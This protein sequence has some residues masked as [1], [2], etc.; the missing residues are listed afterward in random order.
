MLGY[1]KG[2]VEDMKNVKD[3]EDQLKKWQK[4]LETAKA[5]YNTTI[6]DE[7]E[8]LYLGTRTIDPNINN[9]SVSATNRKKA[10]NVYNII[11]EFV[12]SQVDSTIPQSSVRSKLPGSDMLAQMIEDSIK[13]DLAE[14]GINEINDENE[15]TTPIQGLSIIGVDWDPDFRHH[16][17]RGELKLRSYHPK[18]IIPQPGVWKLQ[19]MDYFF[20]LSSVTK[21][22]IKNRYGVD[23]PADSEEYPDINT[24]GTGTYTNADQEKVTECVAWYRDEDGDIGKYT[25]TGTTE[26][27]SM[28]KFFYRRLDVCTKCGTVKGMQDVCEVCGG[29]RFKEEIREKEVLTEPV[30]LM[31]GEVLPAGTEVP[32][33]CPT[34]Y[35]VV[36]R[37]NVP[38]NFSFGGQSDVDVIRDQQDALKK[39]VTIVEEKIMR[40]GAIVTAEEGH[41]FQ[42]KNE[43]YQVIRGKAAQLERLKVV[44]LEADISMDVAFAE[45]MYKVAQST[46]GI[47]DSYQGK[48]DA[49]AQSG[50]AKQIQVQQASGRLQSKIFNKYTAYKELFEIMFEFKL[51]FYDELR[52]YVTQDANGKDVYGDFDKY[53]FLV[54]DKAG[55]LYYNTDFIFSADAGAGLP[56]DKLF[57]YNQAKE[58]FGAKAIDNMQLWQI[59]TDLQFP[60]ARDILSQLEERQRAMEQAQA[61]AAQGQ[62]AI[63]G[64][65]Q[66]DI[67]MEA[68]AN[69][70]PEERAQ[71]QGLPDDQMMA[72]IM[73]G[74]GGGQPEGQM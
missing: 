29:K 71:L 66:E 25:W 49:T 16:L 64:E 63:P 53:K 19:D 41:L 20:I 38:L 51:S 28:P 37:K 35:P 23:L 50:V 60:K 58:L 74:L 36:I 5:I 21:T 2:K 15:R 55:E 12:E 57:L 73:Q 42:L 24:G 13:N 70:S 30:E 69:M 6:M 52:P 39:V 33:F 3:S 18:Q 59:L 67:A 9:S 65:S 54:R 62:N 44:N 8:A 34:R 22:Y 17:Y 1:V 7:R 10:N 48:E 26:L 27:E 56:N 61:M 43:L 4:K 31:S 40:G 46:L 72:V 47:T 14:V 45:K 11:Y 68:L 32:Y